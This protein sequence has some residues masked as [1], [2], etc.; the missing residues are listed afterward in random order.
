MHD[1][2]LIIKDEIAH[3]EIASMNVQVPARLNRVGGDAD[4]ASIVDEDL[5]TA[6]DRATH[7]F[8]QPT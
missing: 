6:L 4:G 2:E 1:N 7:R 3:V 5:N 8:D